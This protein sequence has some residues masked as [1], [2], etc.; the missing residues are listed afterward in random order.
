MPSASRV[1]LHSV[2]DVPVVLS[3][4]NMT[5]AQL[6]KVW[7]CTTDGFK[8][9]LNPELVAP[10]GDI[11]V[12]QADAVSQL[13][14]DLTLTEKLLVVDDG[15]SEVERVE[16]LR[17][18]LKV[19]AV[20]ELDQEGRPQRLDGPWDRRL[21]SSSQDRMGPQLVEW[22]E[23][24]GRGTFGEECVGAHSRAHKCRLEA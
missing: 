12:R 3:L 20:A 22:S 7:V 8:Y 23:R 2:T 21:G 11:L 9:M 13:L 6:E 24:D 5:V 10:G 4:A 17:T 16:L 18:L 15:V 14:H 1:L 19:G